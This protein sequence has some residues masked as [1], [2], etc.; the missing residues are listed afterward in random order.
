MRALMTVAIALPFVWTV[1]MA[2]PGLAQTFSS[3]SSGADGAFTPTTNT[4][5][6]LPASGVFNFTTIS[7]PSGVTVRFTR[8]AANTPVTLVATGNVTIAGTLDVSATN[9]GNVVDGTFLGSNAGVGGPGGFDGGGGANGVAATI[10][11]SGLGPGGGG[12]GAGAGYAAAGGVVSPTGTPGAPYGNVELLP[13]I[14][15]SGG[16]GGDAALGTTSA[17]GGGGGGAI[18]IASSG[19]ITLTG[20][21]NARGGGGGGGNNPGGGGSG[22]AI[23]LIATTITGANGTLDVRGGSGNSGIGIASGGGSVG[24]VRLE[25]YTNSALLNVNA[26]APSVALPSAVALANGPAL[27]ITTIGGVATP[28]APTASF[29]VPDIT[30]PAAIANPVTLT[31]SGTNIPP[32]TVVTVVVNGQT[33]GSTAVSTTLSGTMASTRATAAVTIPTN[34]PCVVSASATF[35]PA[36]AGTAPATIALAQRA[37]SPGFIAHGH[38]DAVDT[39]SR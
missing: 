17:G 9:G 30:L 19:T 13:L 23:R 38:G 22:G 28:A 5:L 1:T 29:S 26:V 24:R 20:T 15:G 35:T 2:A 21:I 36:T 25:A 37:P 34:R 10:G 18:L 39:G 3:G 16:G 8:N 11:G 31:L 32:G 6:T 12:S 14:G 27:T 7:I 4:T 33:G